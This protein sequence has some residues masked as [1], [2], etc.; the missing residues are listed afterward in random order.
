M[1]IPG[2]RDLT[3]LGRGGFST[4][5]TALQESVEREVALKVL[6]VHIAG[7]D[8]KA[9][10]RRECATNGRVGNH[11][12]IVTLFD[13]GFADDGSPYL[14]M[15]LCS[16][17]SLSDRLRAS[18]ALAVAEVLRVGVKIA[19]ALQFAHSAGVLHRDIKPENILVSDFGEPE[20]ADFGI[21]SVDDQRMSTVTASSF[22]IN[23]A[24]PEA[25]AGQPSSVSSDIYSLCS[26]LFTLV[27]GHTPFNAPS[28][29][30]LVALVN[31]V[32]NQ[33]AP[34]TGRPDVPASFEQLLA[35]GL[36][37]TPA[38]RP[39]DARAVGAAL[40]AIQQELGLP[41][42]EFPSAPAP[43]AYSQTQSLAELQQSD[44]ATPGA[45][46]GIAGA[47]AGAGIAAAGVAGLLAGGRGT[48]P[49]SEPP[50][51]A[52][53]PLD[54]GALPATGA[55][56]GHPATGVPPVVLGRPAT[57]VPPVVAAAGP[58]PPSA[59]DAGAAPTGAWGAWADER[60][61]DPTGSGG[62]VPGVPSAI[63]A[64]PPAALAPS[65]RSVPDR[66]QDPPDRRVWWI[67]AAAVLVLLLAGGVYF[68][69][70]RNTGATVSAGGTPTPSGTA[71]KT[72]AGANTTPSRSRPNTTPSSTRPTQSS[73]PPP[74]AAAITPVIDS[75]GGKDRTESDP[76]DC[77]TAATNVQIQLVWNTTDAA[78]AWIGIDSPGGDASAKP[79]TPAGVS[80]GGFGAPFACSA[81]KHTYTLTVQSATG[82]N[83]S[84]SVTFVRKLAEPTTSELTTTSA[85][86]S[87]SADSTPTTPS[88]APAP[89]TPSTPTTAPTTATTSSGTTDRTPT[90]TTSKTTAPN[91]T[92]PNTTAPV[93]TASKTTAPKTTAQTS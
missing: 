33:P 58:V 32:M 74:A 25:L 63:P 61:G 69:A 28:A 50:G 78:R 83:V 18:G 84:K 30:A 29:T 51:S 85:S 76:V 41:V 88:T 44:P 22:T 6:G 91:T 55:M 81:A 37:K 1:Q 48:G 93:T 64:M 67:V 89:A 3:V 53:A 17:G 80:S 47:V 87:T 35:A 15:Q 38:G 7:A 43:L 49:G 2:Y 73:T 56:P 16:G 34:S 26:T 23:H 12:N 8:A 59:P 82:D 71:L 54:T 60:F 45:G 75:Y 19:A 39:S 13:S 77:A 92:A 57:G 46:M 52:A 72:S 24:A 14:A 66:R 27:A 20:L 10:F 36:S 62:Y 5:Y 40:Q 68:V 21:S 4:V 42:T 90:R 79:N 86:Q 31:M 70:T 9:R 65:A 11:P